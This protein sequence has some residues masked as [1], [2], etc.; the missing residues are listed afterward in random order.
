MGTYP[1]DL[2]KYNQAWWMINRVSTDKVPGL[3]AC[4]ARNFSQRFHNG[5]APAVFTYL[6]AHPSQTGFLPGAGPG[7]VVVPH[8]SEIA[9]VFAGMGMVMPGEESDL[10]FQMAQYWTNFAI[11][12][13]PN[14]GNLP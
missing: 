11:T 6:F 3:G 2:G 10:A 12:G 9:F 13:N 1:S 14:G 5:G 8:A 7:S 4:G